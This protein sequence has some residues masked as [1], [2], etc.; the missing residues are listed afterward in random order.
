MAGQSG[1][2]PTELPDVLN[3]YPSGRITAL[4][5]EY[6]S[7]QRLADLLAMGL[8]NLSCLPDPPG[9][10]DIIVATTKAAA[11]ELLLK[12]DKPTGQPWQVSGM[13]AELTGCTGRQQTIS[14]ACASGTVALIQAAK[15][16]M[17]GMSECVLVVGIDLISSFVMAGF[18][19]LKA[20]S[21]NPCNPFDRDRSGLSLGE[22]V[23]IVVMC[24]ETYATGHQLQVLRLEK[25]IELYRAALAR[26]QRVS[27]L[28]RARDRVASR[29][30]EDLRGRPTL[31]ARGRLGAARRLSGGIPERRA[32]VHRVVSAAAGA[33]HDPGLLPPVLRRW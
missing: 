30:P 18:D 10:C 13:V 15:Q 27:A 11:D 14:A 1:L 16:I 17:T 33:R 24:S 22:G 7:T 23:G 12:P 19:S 26:I 29:G 9:N 3:T 25:G 21:P 6:G 31:G 32:L 5:D 8:N 4:G 28:A 2:Q 20:L